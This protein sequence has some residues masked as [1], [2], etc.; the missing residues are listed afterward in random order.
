MTEDGSGSTGGAPGA[1]RAR[2]LFFPIFSYF[3]PLCCSQ[4][5]TCSAAQSE[6]FFRAAL[7]CFLLFISPTLLCS[8]PT[9]RFDRDWRSQKTQKVWGG[10]GLLLGLL[11][12]VKRASL[13]LDFLTLVKED[14][15]C[16][17]EI[18]TACERGGKNGSFHLQFLFHLWFFLKF[19]IIHV[20][21]ISNIY[22]IYYPE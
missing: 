14:T 18:T 19:H 7:L 10:A 4:I 15:V 6:G 20:I 21:L 12:R 1:K 9:E 2:I 16:V 22:F 13:F 8:T 5:P 11:A 17:V 3:F